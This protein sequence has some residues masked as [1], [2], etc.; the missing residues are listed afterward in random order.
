MSWYLLGHL[1]SCLPCRKRMVLQICTAA[2]FDWWNHEF[3]LKG[4]LIAEKEGADRT[5]RW[6]KMSLTRCSL[7][8]QAFLPW[9]LCKAFLPGFADP[10]LLQQDRLS[11]ALTC[12]QTVLLKT[13]AIP[14]YYL[15]QNIHSLP[16]GLA[17]R[18]HPFNTRF[19]SVYRLQ[20]WMVV[21]SNVANDPHWS[22]GL[23]FSSLDGKTLL[24]Q[25][26]LTIW[27]QGRTAQTGKDRHICMS[28]HFHVQIS[29]QAA[30]ELVSLC[31][32]RLASIRFPPVGWCTGVWNTEGL[33]DDL[34]RQAHIDW[35][36][37]RMSLIWRG[38]PQMPGCGLSA[39]QGNNIL[40]Y[41]LSFLRVH[42]PRAGMQIE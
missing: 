1:R 14:W 18:E 19:T 35:L 21:K 25:P 16:M 28:G 24:W 33:Y 11:D 29:R 32:S 30:A 9:H 12:N 41:T 27:Q 2:E 6:A 36:W 31:R 17:L 4:N 5:Y 20:S 26:A 15:I 38:G 10:T 22:Q 42:A 37:M 7:I 23:Y 40:R 8:R 13:G 3:P 34:W 39:L